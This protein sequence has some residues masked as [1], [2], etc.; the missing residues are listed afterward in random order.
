MFTPQ[1]LANGQILRVNP[2]NPNNPNVSYG[3]GWFLNEH[4]GEREVYHSGAQQRVSTL[5]YMLPDKKF[6]VVLMSNL[7]G[8]GLLNLAREIADIVLKGK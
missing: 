3:L 4:N 6:A 8:A 5:L 1:K 2:N 7:E